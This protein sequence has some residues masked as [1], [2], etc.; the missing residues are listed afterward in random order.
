M[1]AT[2]LRSLIVKRISAIEDKEKLAV[3]K[4]LL[5][6]DEY[7]EIY[8]LSEVQKKKIKKAKAEIK[9]GQGIAHEKVMTDMRK[10]LRG[11]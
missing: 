4:N 3:I 5:D 10:W 7:Q 9:K 1:T 8:R 2:K 6:S 11:K